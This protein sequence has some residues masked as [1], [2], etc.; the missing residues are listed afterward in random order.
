MRAW[1]PSGFLV[2]PQAAHLITDERG[3]DGRRA[4]CFAWRGMA[5]HAWHGMHGMAW[6]GSMRH[7]PPLALA[8]FLHNG[9]MGIIV[10]NL[11]LL[12]LLLLCNV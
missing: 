8:S 4:L 3:P 2:Q 5:W 7:F 10:L 9:T 6:R 11:L 1:A 12:L